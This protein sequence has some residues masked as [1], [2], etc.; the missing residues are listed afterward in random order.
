MTCLIFGTCCVCAQTEVKVWTRTLGESD[1]DYGYAM[2]TDPAK[3]VIVTGRTHSSLAG[4]LSGTYDMFVAKY[5]ASGNRQW[6]AQRGT[7]AQESGEG[8]VTDS[9][10]NVYVTGYTGGDLDGN[11]SAGGWDIFLMKFDAAGNWKWT[12][13]DGTGQDDDSHAIAMDSAG[14]IYITGYV[15]GDFHGLTRVGSSDIFI[16]KYNQAGTRHWSVLFGSSAVDEGF[17]IAC[18][19]SNNVYVTGYVQESVEGNPWLGTGDN[20]LAKYDSEGQRQWLKQWG[21]GNADTG[22]AVTCDPVGSVYVGGYSNGELYGPKNGGRDIFLAKYGGDG[23]FLWGAQ[24][25]TLETDQV[26]GMTTDTN[27]NV[28]LAGETGGPLQGNLAVGG[29]DVFFSKFSSGGT[30]LW[31]QQVGTPD[32]DL[33][34]GIALDASGGI[35]IAGWTTGD[36]DGYVNK[37]LS[38]VFLM[39]YALSNSAPPAPTA[40]AATGVTV[41]GFTA[42]WSSASWAAGY[43]LDVST[44]SAFGSFVA[45]Y[46]NRD[47]GNVLAL[48]VSGLAQGTAYYYRVRAYGGTGTSDNSSTINATTRIPHCTAGTLLNGSFDGSYASGI[49]ANWTSY[50]R[51]PNPTI[52]LWSI[53]TAS[54]PSGGGLQ[55]QQIATTNS[56][57]GAGVRQ[58]I[59]GCTIGSTYIISG[60]MRGNS[61]SSTCTV[62]VSP[63]AS[64]IWSTAIHLTPP[65]TYSGTTWVPFSGTVVATGNTM[66][67]WLDGQT[68]GTRNFNT[69]CFDGVTVSCPPEFRLNATA[70]L[71]PSRVN[72]VVSNA[73]YA[74]VTIQQSSDLVNWTVLTNMAA[75]NGTARFTDT[76]TTNDARRFYNATSP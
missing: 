27:G 24:M 2:A 48:A 25:G 67:L 38:D 42:N 14:N 34:A 18:D 61:A 23:T 50:L 40:L 62:K 70:V 56:T 45:G 39:K 35:Y 3:N 1:Y 72:L 36:F 12:V 37:G 32:T 49:G 19:K 7:S 46:Q 30:E 53:Q 20:I 52:V 41:S 10:G 17:G 8:V 55:Y 33:A 29:P 73:P 58:N 13:Q 43:R 60:W 74:S 11:T 66:T 22:H 65:Q 21:T 26:W 44:N 15:R 4:A 51:A 9:A 63:T 76:A 6:M 75:I 5:D 31:T 71:S 69:A 59:T 16:S 68:S 47:A 54:P 57:G 28:Y 64:T